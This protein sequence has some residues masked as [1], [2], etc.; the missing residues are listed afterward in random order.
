MGGCP[1][2]VRAAHWH[3]PAAY[4]FVLHLDRPALAWEYLRRNPGYRR[5]WLRHR[6][7]DL[8]PQSWCLRQF[9]DPDRDARDLQ[10]A[11][12]PEVDGAIPLHPDI[13]PPENAPVFH[14][15]DIPGR[16]TLTDDGRQLR[17]A[18][19]VGCNV[20]RLTITRELAD[21]MPYAYAVRAGPLADARW[22]AIETQLVVLN[23]VPTVSR[24][25]PDRAVLAHMRAL[26]A[27]DG[28]LAGASHR[29][30][31]EVVFG[32]RAVAERWH[33]DGELRAQVRRMIRAG[34]ALMNGGYRRLLQ[35]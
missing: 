21:G 22:R 7:D 8:S 34:K 9:E 2:N 4:L 20:A 24:S 35:M 12:I 25:R 27:L 14:L 28:V 23:T 26:Q 33:S 32:G 18:S 6:E 15:W 13:D 16:K 19:A 29:Q 10:P 31:A 17:L 3:P 11:W 1:L 5:D 30:I